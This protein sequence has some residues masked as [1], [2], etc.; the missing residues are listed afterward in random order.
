MACPNG[1][2]AAPRQLPTKPSQIRNLKNTDFVGMVISKVL[3]DIPTGRNQLL[4]LA[5][6]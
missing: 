5:D 4:K 6:E 3:R 1:E 2:G